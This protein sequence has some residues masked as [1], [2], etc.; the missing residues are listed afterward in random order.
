MNETSARI[1]IDS[2]VLLYSIESQDAGKS[3]HAGRWLD[4]LL[5]T[6]SGVTNL[7]VLNEVTNVLLKRRVMAPEQVFKV[8]D[9]FGSFGTMPVS[10]EIMT[11]AR[12]IRLSTRYQ[13]WDCLLLASAVE[14]RCAGFL[15]E[16]MSDG[17]GIHGLTIINPFLHSPPQ[18]RFH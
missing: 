9:T 12:L 4:Y 16:D 1:F 18:L 8:V 5:Q 2:N 3:V 6:G 14:L 17:P 11:A 10:R 13:W 15:S 7:Q